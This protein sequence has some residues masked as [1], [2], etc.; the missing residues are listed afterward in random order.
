MVHVY[1][2]LHACI[3]SN[4]VHYI[5]IYILHYVCVYM[6]VCMYVCTYIYIYTYT[7][8]YAHMIHVIHIQVH[9]DVT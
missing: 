1:G 8:T 2:M 4:H 6:Y 7:H 9:E 5:H 3:N